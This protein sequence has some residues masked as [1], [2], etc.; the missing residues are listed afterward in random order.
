MYMYICIHVH[1]H[2]CTYTCTYVYMYMY[3]CVHV[4]GLLLTSSRVVCIQSFRVD[5][6]ENVETNT[7]HLVI[8]RKEEVKER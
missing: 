7:V 4:Y 3:I 8:Q 1:V 2:M 6:D 5:S